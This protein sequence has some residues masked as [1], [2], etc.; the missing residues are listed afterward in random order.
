[1]RRDLV[2]VRHLEAQGEQPGLRGVA[3]DHGGLRASGNGRGPGPQVTAEGVTMT[4]ALVSDGCV[5]VTTDA[6]TNA[7][8]V[9][10]VAMNVRRMLTSLVGGA[11][12]AKDADEGPSPSLVSAKQSTCATIRTF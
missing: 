4:W 3:L 8:A 12:Q 10:V 9:I 2:S 5:P 7:A 6:Q 11:F 1:M